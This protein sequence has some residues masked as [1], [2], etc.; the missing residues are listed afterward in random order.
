MDSQNECILTTD[1]LYLLVVRFVDYTT[2]M[3][4]FN[5]Y[6]YSKSDT[7]VKYSEAR[8]SPVS[9]DPADCI[10]LSRLS[11][12]SGLEA[13]ENLKGIVD[14]REGVFIEV[15]NWGNRGSFMMETLKENYHKYVGRMNVSAKINFQLD[16]FWVYCASIDRKTDIQ[17]TGQMRS[18][19]PRYDFMAG[20]EDPSKFAMQLGRDIIHQIALDKDPQINSN[21]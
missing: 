2:F 3:P 6:S 21:D 4:G 1:R 20:I 19:S 10:R 18:L 13:G 9:S 11:Y 15:L 16:D 7:L 14:N 17:R 12:Y 8:F 5:R